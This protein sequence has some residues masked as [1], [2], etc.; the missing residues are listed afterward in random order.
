M[1]AEQLMEITLASIESKL[2]LLAEANS[3]KW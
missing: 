1:V 3:P 2:G